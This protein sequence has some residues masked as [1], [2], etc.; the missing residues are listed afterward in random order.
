MKYA[1]R[2]LA[3]FLS[4]SL[5][6]SSTGTVLAFE[7][8][9]LASI[10]G[11]ETVGTT[12]SESERENEQQ[13]EG[14]FEV[15]Q[16]AAAS[17]GTTYTEMLARAEAIVNY[18]WTPSQQIATWN[19]SLYK[20]RS[21]FA[22]GETVVGMPYTLF[23]SEI[24]GD[25]LLSLEQYR[26]MASS[27][28]STAK[29][30]NS[31]SATRTGPVYG[32]CCATFVSE[33]FG[34]RF[35]NGSNPVYDSVNGIK[36][37]SYGTTMNNVTVQNIRSGDALSLGNSHIIWV[38]DVTDTHITI[39]EQTPPVARKVVVSKSSVNANGY[40]LYEGNVYS[41]VT[42][43]KE[44]IINTDK[45]D[46]K[47]AYWGDSTDTTFRP[48]I[49]INN[50][51]AVKKVKFAVWTGD[52]SDL[53]WYAANYNGEGDYFKDIP[54]SDFNGKSYWCHIYVYGYDGS[55]QGIN[56]GQLVLD[57]PDIKGAYWGD[58]TDTTFRPVIHINNPAS[59]KKVKFAVWTGDQSDLKWYSANYNGEGDYFKDI[60]YSDFNG[61]SYWCHIYVYGYDGSEQG[62]NLGQLVLDK[63]NIQRD[64]KIRCWMSDTDMGDAED[65]FIQ[66]EWYY[67]CYR[68]FDGNT[69]E[70]LDSFWDR[71][72]TVTEYIYYPNGTV[73][74][75]CSYNNDNNWIALKCT[76]PGRYTFKVVVEGDF[77]G[78]F[79]GDFVVEEAPLTINTSVRSVN[80]K[81]GETESQKI[82]VMPD[83]YYDGSYSLS[84]SRS[85]SNVKCTWGTWTEEGCPL[86]ITAENEGTTDVTVSIIDSST[87]EVLVSTVIR[88]TV[89]RNEYSIVYNANGGSGAPS[90]QIKEHGVNTKISNQ[91]PTRPGYTF[92]G[93]STSSADKTV[94]YNSG[95]IYSYNRAITLYAV[96]K[97]NVVEETD[98][99]DAEVILSAS[100]YVY[101]GSK[102]NPNVTIKLGDKTLSPGTDYI[103]SYNNN[104]NAGTA[105]V[106]IT[107][108]G[109][110]VGSISKIYTITPYALV[111]T[112]I[113]LSQT[114]F[115]Y[116]G[117]EHKPV[118]TVQMGNKI[119]KVDS[120][121]V[122][123]Y[124]NNVEAGTAKVTI[125]GIGNFAGSIE[126]SF[127]IQE[128]EMVVTYLVTFNANGGKNLSES[129]RRIEENHAVGTLPTVVKDGYKFKGWYTASIGGEKITKDTVITSDISFYAQW[130]NV[131]ISIEDAIVSL[132]SETFRYDGTEQQP[133]VT[134]TL[135]GK[136]LVLDTD[137]TV[138]Y[139]NNV[140]IGTATVK[141]TGKGNY[142]GTLI[143][144]FVIEVKKGTV[145]T[146]GNY[147]YK[148][149]S[150]SA[151]AFYGL[152]SKENVA[153]VIIPK[154][155]K[156]GG[157]T[158]KVTSVAKNALKG[159][160]KVK[161]VSVGDNV[162]RIGSSAFAGC[163]KLS[164]VNIGKKVKSIDVSA[165]EGCKT[166]S[167]VKIGNAVT[168]IGSKAFKNCTALKK[169]VLPSKVTKIDKQAFYGCKNLK[170]I[171]ITS[172]K[173]KTVGKD[174]FKKINAKAIIEVPKS[175][176]TS[177]KKLLKGKG[178]GRNVKIVKLK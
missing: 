159:K 123:K 8:D 7:T 162:T 39:Y 143:E 66:G 30:C 44:L 164:E 93:W 101:D 173:L 21:Y 53:K 82:N 43:S 18:T 109:K 54:Y 146:V 72:Y 1:K 23:T 20:G 174:A 176:F 171:T 172:T 69:N 41:V 111:N 58:S 67:L 10:I 141:I 154:S 35:M 57:K 45:P 126:K 26:Q 28:Y 80:L 138:G 130:E 108:I 129:S 27:N 104:I 92:L 175:K 118:V 77:N 61:K 74:T 38:G 81:I 147:K 152:A 13:I 102:K 68:M 49:H 100:S 34:G 120:D 96:W 9:V 157:K 76:V 142:K 131:I 149:T 4:L 177:Y 59:V 16:L 85:N 88:V 137:Y 114:E 178:Q 134:V 29:Y 106:V 24:V 155:V 124:T 33:V 90:T 94:A 47:G 51:D 22:K 135:D 128:P 103:V 170:T 42:R 36:N 144:T 113:T 151:T 12:E 40:L 71:S 95:D 25:S 79:E 107:G 75:S 156:Y 83:G 122:L 19:G 55:E 139:K 153:T 48:I 84:W 11:T 70:L 98:I 5:L 168:T 2:I 87:R 17:T 50:P 117:T 121:Y 65:S 99:S 78:T 64:L 115:L 140:N 60:P 127:S 116:N 150:S 158:F 62:I 165:F 73:A 97:Q 167:K 169:I 86:T 125:T 110:Y 3:G 15:T 14:K 63:P 46:V 105:T 160:T 145:F 133:S 31:V 37:S 166:L 148:V 132:S 91:L 112:R 32:S 119:L 56:L 136:T 161:R 89:T 6:F 163:T 52:Q